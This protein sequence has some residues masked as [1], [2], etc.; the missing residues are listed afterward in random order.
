MGG[1]GR[2]SVWAHWRLRREEREELATLQWKVEVLGA[3]EVLG[4]DK[5]GEESTLGISLEMERLLALHL[6][7][8]LSLHHLSMQKW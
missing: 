7:L 3:M 6:H 5:G 2:G 8:Q 1:E 4:V